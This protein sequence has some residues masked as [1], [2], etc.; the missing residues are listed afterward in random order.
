MQFLVPFLWLHT[1]LAAEDEER[2]QPPGAVL[3]LPMQYR[4]LKEVKSHL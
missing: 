3:E 2:R 1:E 4:E